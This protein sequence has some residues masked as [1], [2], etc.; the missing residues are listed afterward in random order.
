MRLLMNVRKDRNG[1]SYAIKK[2]PGHLQEAVARVLNHG[3]PRQTWLKRSLRT[4]DVE[5][6]NRNAK[7]VLI[8]FDRILAQA[9]AL[10]AERPLR[11][12][13]SAR[14][15]EQIAHYFYA[16]ELA[17]DEDERREGGSEELSQAALKQLDE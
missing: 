5:Q 17:A 9:E 16:H 14:E 6:A 7:P 12:E 2:V 3:R 11:S 1:N 4:K 13:L 15:I 8:E 10:Q